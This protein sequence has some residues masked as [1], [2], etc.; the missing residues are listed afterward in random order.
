ENQAALK[1]YSLFEPVALSQRVPL[2]E[3]MGFRVISEQT[4]EL[5]DL[6]PDPMYVHDMEI[7]SAFDRPIDLSDEGVLFEDMFLAV[8]K[9]Q[10]DNDRYNALVHT[11]GLRAA[12]IVILRTYGRYLQQAGIAQSQDF[13]AGALNRYPGIADDLFNLFVSRFDIGR[14]DREAAAEALVARIEE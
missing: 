8:W 7:E 1:I 2:L 5:E 14:T 6:G 11:G 4:F 9:Q 3:N 10:V 13:I 12:D